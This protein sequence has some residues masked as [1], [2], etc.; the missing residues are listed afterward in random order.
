MLNDMKANNDGS[1]Q[2]QVLLDKE[3]EELRYKIRDIYHDVRSL[4][5]ESRL[6]S[7]RQES[8]NEAV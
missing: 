4:S 1:N 7:I 5:T 6:S 3:V 8:T 2:E